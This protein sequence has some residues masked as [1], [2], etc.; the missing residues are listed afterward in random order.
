MYERDLLPSF[1]GINSFAR[2]PVGTVA[3]LESGMVAVVGVTHDGTSSSRQGVRLGPKSIREASADFIF[4][5]QGSSTRSMVNILTG[6]TIVLPQQPKLL[7]LRDLPTYPTD[8]KR[9][10]EVCIDSVSAIMAKGAF[11]VTLGGD[12]YVTYGL[13]QG[14]KN[15]V[16]QRIGL[17]QLSSQLDLG[18]EDAVWGRDWH[19]A[20]LRRILDGGLVDGK[21]AVFVG[22]QGYVPNTEWELAQ[23]LRATVITA[24]SMKQRGAEETARQALEVAGNGC[25]AI[26]LSLDIDVVDSGFAS[27]TG[28]LVIGGLV[29]AE[30]L[31]MMVE[32][33]RSDK[34]RGLDV[35]EV[36]P[37]LDVR[38][39]SERLAA[40]AIIELIAPRVFTE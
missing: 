39:R 7:D 19:G 34:I 14:F 6:R 2:M 31:A 32:F 21:N 25:D 17:I 1:A 26:Y 24:D 37:G 33:S 36:A 13:V 40:E 8:L 16:G 28:D 4:D 29:P 38:G 10:M 15:A 9:T 22:T 20:T 3:E 12:H 23:S 30:L 27:G 35:V 11:P 5:V 18:D